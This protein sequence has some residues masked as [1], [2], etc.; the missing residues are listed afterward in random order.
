ME[1]KKLLIISA[2]VAVLAVST[3]GVLALLT[4][5][6]SITGLATVD[7]SVVI[8]TDDDTGGCH[9]TWAEQST[10]QCGDETETSAS[11][12]AEAEGGD[13]RDVGIR[14]KNRGSVDA[15]VDVVV[16][17]SVPEGASWGTDVVVQ[18]Y[19]DYD[20]VDEECLGEPLGTYGDSGDSVSAGEVPADD[21]RWVCVRQT[22]DIAA[23]PGSYDFTA[24]IN[25]S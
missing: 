10:D 25:P 6:A 8:D 18:L 7:Q 17:G 12:S 24:D 21:E 9:L 19:G 15:P 11:W 14:L 2:A 23:T 3:T 16:S 13:T 20:P 1:R 22:W 5:Y 4:N